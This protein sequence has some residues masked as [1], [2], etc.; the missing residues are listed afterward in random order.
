[1]TETR[2]LYRRT[3]ITER[4]CVECQGWYAPRRRDALTCGLRCRMRR[5]RAKRRVEALTAPSLDANPERRDE[6]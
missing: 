1:M 3:A 5:H 2:T 6:P 4:R